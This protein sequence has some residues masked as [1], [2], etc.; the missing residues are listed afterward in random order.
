[1]DLILFIFAIGYALTRPRIA[2]F[3]ATAYPNVPTNE[4]E[5]WKRLELRSRDLIIWTGFGFFIVE[6]SVSMATHEPIFGKL[7]AVHLIAGILLMVSGISK[8][9]ANKIKKR[10]NIETRSYKISD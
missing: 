9:R 6:L 4:F 8:L 5:K 7:W 2:A 1:M 3:S 10:Y